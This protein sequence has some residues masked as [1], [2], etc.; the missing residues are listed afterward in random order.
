MR[1]PAPPSLVDPDALSSV[2]AFHRLFQC[3]IL[4]RPVLPPSDRCRLRVSL[5]EEEV[6]EL[7][8]AIDADDL[9]E[10]ADALA[11]IQYVLS[12]A[13]L[14][15]GMG[16]IFKSLFDEVQRSNMSKA[17]TTLEEAEQT[18]AHYLETKGTESLIEN[19]DGQWLVYREEDRK[20]LKSIRYS[21]ANLSGILR[22]ALPPS[23]PP[24]SKSASS[25]SASP[26]SVQLNPAFPEA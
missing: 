11:D 16:G 2:A 26:T 18:R 17:C 23:S 19:V 20:V 9:I 10:V 14:E 13:V 5:L 6:G 8:D 15:F 22:N 4:A 3:P 24:S 21:P 25:T 7:A 1:N 12:G